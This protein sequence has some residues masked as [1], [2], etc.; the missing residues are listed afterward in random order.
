MTA[1][2][3]FQNM[4]PLSAEEYSALEQS[5]KDHGVQVPIIVDENGTVIDGHHRQKITQDLGIRC[6]S[7]V[8]TGKAESEKRTLALSLNLDRRHLNREQRRALIAESVKADP[9]L[10]NREHARRTGADHKT[11]AAVRAPLTESGEIPHFSERID[12]RTGNAS[13]PASRPPRVDKATGEIHDMPEDQFFEAVDAATDE[14]FEQALASAKAQGD[15]SRTNVAANLPPAEPPAPRRRPLP[16]SFFDAAYDLQKNIERL[17]RLVN[18]D[19]FQSNKE[20]VARNHASDLQR[21]SGTLTR[22]LNQLNN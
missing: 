8:V 14:Q 4:P 7:T 10:S 18:D 9:Q 22:I 20:Q 5:I 12:P 13:Q 1:A 3:L 16:D 6:P 21:A 2:V 17:E 11:V 19:R 15:A